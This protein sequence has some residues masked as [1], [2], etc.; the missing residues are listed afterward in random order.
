MPFI[1]HLES[2]DELVDYANT[3]D[4]ATSHEVYYPSGEASRFHVIKN[5]TTDKEVCTVSD[6]YAILQHNDALN[7]IISGIRAAGITGGG[8]MRNYHDNVVVECFFDNLT[9]RDHSQDGHIQLGMRFTNS[10]NKSVGFSGEAYSWRQSCANGMLTSRLLP[11]APHIF[12]K[13]MG[14]VVERITNNV[15]SFVENI[16]KMEGSLLTIINEARNEIITFESH[17]QLI[18]YTSQFVGSEK[19]AKQIFEIEPVELQSTKWDLYNALTSVVSH[20]DTLSYHQYTTIHNGAQDMLLKP[21]VLPDMSREAM[22]IVPRI[23]A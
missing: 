20:D 23:V 1:Q 8:V 11:N 9:V 3:L 5:D 12:F 2:L 13:H 14:D 7:L 15:K 10:F 21:V 18:R 19:R 17:D 16:V 22:T 4:R 6:K